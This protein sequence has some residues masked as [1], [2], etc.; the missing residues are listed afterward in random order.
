M[1]VSKSALR[2]GLAS[3]ALS[4]AAVTMAASPASADDPYIPPL[5]CGVANQENGPLSALVHG[6]E[7]LL[8]P[9]RLEYTLHGLNCAVVIN[10]EYLL[11]LKVR[12]FPF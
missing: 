11:G 3:L 10:T 12:P 2:I 9:L 7:P 5:S 1:A 4:G 8:R 6:L